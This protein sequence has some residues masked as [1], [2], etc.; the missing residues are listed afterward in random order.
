MAMFG[1][2]NDTQNKNIVNNVIDELKLNPLTDAI[3]RQV[4]PT[5]QPVF[6]VK[7]KFADILRGGTIASTSSQTLYTTPSDRDFYLTGACLSIDKSATCDIASG[8]YTMVCTINGTANQAILS[9]AITTLTAQSQSVSLSFPTSIK[10]DRGTVIA[11]SAASF[12][13]G[14]FVRAGSIVG[15]TEE[16]GNNLTA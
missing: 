11:L 10:V 9:V 13:A 14:T 15:F 3:P 7:K 4:I 2:F 5:I 8:R 12:S 16:A 1:N 6:E